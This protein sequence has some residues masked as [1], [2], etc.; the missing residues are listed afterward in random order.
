MPP[1]PPSPALFIDVDGTLLP[2]AERP[3]EV[4]P[5]STLLGQLDGLQLALGGALAILSRWFCQ[6]PA[7]TAWKDDA[8]TAPSS[9]SG[10]IL[11]LWTVLERNFTGSSTA[12]RVCMSRTRVWPWRF[13]IATRPSASAS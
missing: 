10:L 4:R 6:P 2:I 8:P 9:R 12:I 7:C 13:I 1:V 5:D 3:D 11:G